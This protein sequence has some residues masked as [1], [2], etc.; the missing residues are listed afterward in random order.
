LRSLRDWFETYREL[1]GDALVVF[2]GAWMAFCFYLIITRGGFFAFEPRHWVA[3]VEFVLSIA[4]AVLGV[5]RMIC[6]VR[7]R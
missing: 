3:K 6:D 1:L 2:F 5:E 7:A 4:I